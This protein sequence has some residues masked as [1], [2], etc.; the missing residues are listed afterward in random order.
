MK[1]NTHLSFAIIFFSIASLVGCVSSPA[2]QTTH[3]S[4]K[5]VASEPADKSN[6]KARLN[7]HFQLWRGTPYKIAGLNK[8]GIDCSGFVYVT[9][10]DVFGKKIPRTTDRRRP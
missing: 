2:T 1:K 7:K 8:R 6:I 10:R 5:T 9:Y 3:H 4:K